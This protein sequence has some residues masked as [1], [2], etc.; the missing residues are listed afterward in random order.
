MLKNYLKIALRNL[1]RHKGYSLIN[2]AGLAVGIACCLLILLYV[3]DELAYDR[4][5]EKAG[6]IYRAALDGRLADKD[7]HFAVSCAPLAVILPQEL[8]E[9][10]AS[11]RLRN[12]SGVL[13]R[14]GEKRFTED[15]IFYADSTVFGVFTF[16]LVQGDPKTALA[17]PNAI[18]L[19]VAMA[20]KYF[21]DENPIGKTLALDD[22]DYQ[23]TG[24]MQDA[25]R[26]SHFH[27]DFLAAMATLPDS[28][29]PSWLNNNFYTYLVLPANTSAT[30]FEAKVATVVKKYVD[31]QV[32]AA[33]GIGFD[34]FVASGGRY[35]YYLQRLPDIHLHS[36]LDVEIEANGDIKYLYIFSAIA[37]FILLI[38]CINFMN[39][40]TAR[41]A[42]RAKEVGIR[43]V[44]GS[45]RSQ[46]VQQFL[47]ESILISVIALL[48]AIGLAELLLP[49]FNNLAAKQ[50]Q[51]DFLSGNPAR[52][53]LIGFALLVGI[54]AG[55]YPAFFLASFQPVSVLKGKLSRP[56]GTGSRWLRSGLVVFQ[57]AISIALIAGTAVVQQQ[58]QYVQRQN[59][60]FDKEHVVVIQK[61]GKLKQ[62]SPAFKQEL[63]RSPEVLNASAAT[64]VPGR[65][66]SNTT[67]QP[68]GA[69]PDRFELLWYL[70]ADED[71]VK[72]LGMK[73]IAGRNFSKAFSTDS[74]AVILNE[75]AVKRLGL[76]EAVGKKIVLM[77]RTREESLK[78]TVIGVLKDFHFESLR[79]EIRPLALFP[80]RALRERAP[81]FVAVRLRPKN[82]P[83]TLAFLENKWRE[84]VPHH[85]FEYSFLDADFEALYR[86]EQRTG[87]IFGAF[88]ALAILIACLGLFGLASFMTEQRTK[89][90]GVRKVLGASVAQVVILLSKDFTR[91]VLIALMIA[92]PAAYLAMNRWLQDFAYR[93][94][95]SWWVFAL[96]GSVALFIALLTVSTQAIKA[97]L[98][99][100]VEALRYE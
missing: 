74:S 47:S 68:E 66:F 4:H 31:P 45:F 21:G 16:P 69:P 72:T 20:A 37:V 36:K 55:S 19:T 49:F 99:N 7:F 14:S 34:E 1:L 2:V 35:R 89:E 71:F 25:P 43:K 76:T 77:G 8:P 46:L 18:V 98:A 30:E 94:E 73:I 88:S 59:L 80:Q 100:P 81:G 67:V 5:H 58:L 65:W 26:Q 42:N 23:I 85:P 63:L 44:L 11:T 64:E 24:V 50:L 87:R 91:L 9:V 3:Q 84:F 39:L 40:A 15:H 83:A 61:A 32:K 54:I 70:A 51:A 12:R 56:G 29:D 10:L 48:I 86:A 93:I 41:S 79:Q 78:F 96:A 92:A 17:H 82:L 22:Q 57:F 90:I 28:R 75:T 95:I 33:V 6:Q 38:A 53:G 27:P 13:V 52:F 97:A 60:G 62:Q